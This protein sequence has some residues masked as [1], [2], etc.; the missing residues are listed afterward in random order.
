MHIVICENQTDTLKSLG[1][2][3]MRETGWSLSAAGVD[4]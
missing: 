1:E 3:N 2:M 4:T